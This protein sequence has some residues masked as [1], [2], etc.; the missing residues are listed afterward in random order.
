MKEA[1]VTLIKDTVRK[2]PGI[3]ANR[4]HSILSV[5]ARRSGKCITP[6]EINNLIKDIT[7]SGD[8]FKISYTLK[9]SSIEYLNYYYSK[10]VNICINDIPVNISN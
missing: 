10:D 1:L 4:L 3:S 9:D 2:L 7:D 5:E 8:I 6:E